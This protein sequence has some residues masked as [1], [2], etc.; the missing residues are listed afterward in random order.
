MDINKTKR[1]VGSYNS[2][3]HDPQVDKIA[4]VEEDINLTT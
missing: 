3:D 2:V 1:I 4:T